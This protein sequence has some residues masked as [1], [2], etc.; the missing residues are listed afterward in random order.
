M[1]KSLYLA[2]S[3][4]EANLARQLLTEEVNF[5][6]TKVSKI[7]IRNSKIDSFQKGRAVFKTTV[8][9]DNKITRNHFEMK[10]SQHQKYV[11]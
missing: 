6:H 3:A 4:A 8:N 1:S 10:Q 11:H 7:P 5:Y 9:L 2:S